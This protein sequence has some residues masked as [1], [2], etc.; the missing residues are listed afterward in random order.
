MNMAIA[1]AAVALSED[2]LADLQSLVNRHR[3][4]QQIA[5]RARIIMLAS[6]GYNHREIARE[7]N[8]T[9]DTAR[10]W[11]NRWLERGEHG[12]T[13][14]ERLQ[15]AARS[16]APATFTM[17]Q[18]LHLFALA[19][20]PPETYQRPISHWSARELADELMKQGIV[21]RISPRHVARLLDEADLKPHQSRYWL[22]PPK[23]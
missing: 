7:L 6:K 18:I 17:E 15:D 16:G 13:V 3:T 12:H 19:C 20:E 5:L 10:S 2:E 23:R 9:R 8:T 11:R 4:P 22:T 14:E 1:P 21:E